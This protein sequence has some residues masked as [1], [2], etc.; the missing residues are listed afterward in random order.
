MS[1]QERTMA[2]LSYG[3]ECPRDLLRKLEW[4]AEKLS[5]S[6][7]PYDVFNFMLTAAALAEWIQKFYSSDTAPEPFAVPIKDRPSWLLPRTAAQWI[8]DTNCVP[9]TQ[10]GI[11]RDIANAL[12]ICRHIANASKHFYWND[13]RNVSAIGRDPPIRDFYAYCFTS[14]APDL[15]VSYQNENYGLQQIKDILLQFYAGQIAYLE[16]PQTGAGANQSCVA[17]DA[18]R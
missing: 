5:E 18:V 2:H 10:G 7:H 3:I 4:D 9:N 16:S 1:K 12:S 14:T 11:L 17:G 8:V 15:Y 6:P 13:Q